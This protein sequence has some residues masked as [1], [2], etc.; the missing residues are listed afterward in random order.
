M[1]QWGQSAAERE[2]R[3]CRKVFTVATQ[4]MH[5]NYKLKAFSLIKD[6]MYVS[7]DRYEKLSYMK[8]FSSRIILVQN[9]YRRRC[10]SKKTKRAL[11]N[12][13]WDRFVE[14]SKLQAGLLDKLQRKLKTT[15]N[16]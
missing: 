3:L 1:K 13:L 15:K 11:L 10:A 16:K 2:R 9:A 6:F 8:T 5:D 12:D 7:A 4:P 14:R